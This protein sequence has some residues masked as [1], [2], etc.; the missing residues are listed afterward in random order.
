M[1]PIRRS[2]RSEIDLGAVLAL[3]QICT[4]PQNIYDPPTLSDFHRL[5]APEVLPLPALN[6]TL[7][8]G[9]MTQEQVQRMMT[10]RMTAVWEESHGTRLA[11]ALI[12][13]PGRVLTFQVHPQARG[14]GLEAAILEWGVE[15]MQ[16][17]IQARRTSQDL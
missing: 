15:Q 7:F 14:Q 4:T 5:L 8:R 16:T 17:I 1:K 13:Q 10:Q 6:D 2:Y 12:A 9:E 3:K 11:Y